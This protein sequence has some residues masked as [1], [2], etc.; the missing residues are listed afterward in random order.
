MGLLM[1]STQDSIF[2]TFNQV[3]I[4][5]GNILGTCRQ[6]NKNKYDIVAF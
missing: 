1:I 2:Y 4:R 3:L 5:S 6:L